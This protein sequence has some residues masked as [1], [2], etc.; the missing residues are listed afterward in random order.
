MGK[1]IDPTSGELWEAFNKANK[2]I[3]LK[4]VLLNGVFICWVYLLKTG[5]RKQLL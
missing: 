1:E 2:S 5:R 4:Q 3:K